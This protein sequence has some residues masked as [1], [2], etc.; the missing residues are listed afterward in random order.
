MCLVLAGCAST[1]QSAY[2]DQPVRVTGEGRTYEEARKNAFSTAMEYAV[3]AVVVTDTQIQ[4]KRLVKDDILKHSSGYVDDFT[5][6]SRIDGKDSVTVIMDVKVKHSAIAERI[7]NIQSSNGQIQGERLDGLHSSFIQS[8]Q[9][10]DHLLR[11]VL[12]DYPKHAFNVKAG[13]VEYMLNINRLPVIIVPYEVTWNYKYLTALNEALEQTQNKKD[14]YIKQ[15]QIN[16]ISKSPASWLLGS[17]D[18]YYFNDEIRSDMIK[19]GLSKMIFVKTTLRD[20]AGNILKVGCD[21]GRI[22]SGTDPKGTFVID[23]NAIIEEQAERIVKVNARSMSDISSVE[24][25]IESQ[26]CTFIN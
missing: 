16:V 20:G 13:T 22:M 3:G 1:K 15:E 18:K 8:R 6:I 5:I 26:P 11:K 12:D 14:R 4:N 23:G 2:I 24:V 17:T 7:I 21:N 10:G 9:T 19:R 25:S